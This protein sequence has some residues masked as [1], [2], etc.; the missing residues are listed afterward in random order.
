MTAAHRSGKAWS[1]AGE[2]AACTIDVRMLPRA[3][4]QLT[5]AIEKAPAL[6][7][8]G[9]VRERRAARQVEL[10]IDRTGTAELSRRS[11]RA[12]ASVGGEGDGR[13]KAAFTALHGTG[14]G[15]W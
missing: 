14:R 7:A 11:R 4:S 10:R 12:P 2:Q 8:S 5:D 3:S 13:A 6:V 9:R 1:P 15:A